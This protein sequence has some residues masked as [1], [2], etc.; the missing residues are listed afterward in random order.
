MFSDLLFRIARFF[1]SF[2]V[3]RPVIT[4]VMVHRMTIRVE[5]R[6]HRYSLWTPSDPKDPMT[7][8]FD[9]AG[10]RMPN[11]DLATWTNQKDETPTAYPSWTG[12][13]SR[14]HTGRH[15][16][17]L[18][19][20]AAPPRPKLEDV[21]AVQARQTFVPSQHT[22]VLLCFFAQWFTD[23]FLRTHPVKHS[24]TT[25]NH[26]ID[27]CQ[28]YGLD[29]TSTHALRLHRHGLLSYRGYPGAE[30]PL[31]LYKNGVLDKGF[32][33]PDSETGLT[34]LR[35]GQDKRWEAG[36]EKSLKVAMDSPRKGFLYA[37]GLDRGSSTIL[38]SAFNT[39]FLR[40]HNRIARVLR[41]ANRDWD[42]NRL[43]EIARL[44]NIR[45]LLE[46]VMG[47]YIGHLTGG[48]SVS[49]LKGLGQEGA[50]WYRTNRISI[51]FNLLYRWHALIPE[52]FGLGGQNLGEED[53]R[54]NNQ[55]LETHGVAAVIDAGSRQSAGALTLFNT[56]TFMKAAEG[57]GLAWAREFGV[58]GLNAYRRRFG[59]K[60]YATIAEM[61]GGGTA[62]A[63]L[64]RIYHGDVEAV[65]FSVGLFAEK[66]VAGGYLPETL[67]D[68]VAY[69][70]FTHIF[71]NP[72]LGREVDVPA[73]FSRAG[74]DLLAEPATLA[75][76]VR[77]NTAYDPLAQGMTPLV[78]LGLA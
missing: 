76:I 8:R 26:E 9:L 27:L 58:Q 25:S 11:G 2:S 10:A 47:D 52:T 50:N 14:R 6:P 15:L 3:L 75:D 53:F 1:S 56:P 63:A 46:I 16:P 31:L 64:D 36:I 78:R 17:P 61:T 73:S 18:E 59:L 40:E 69:D 60:P 68:I 38:Y 19:T 5:P 13:V 39:L 28:I 43:F 67:R 23:S 4:R 32:F 7:R 42:D 22:S 30:Y 72:V 37:S 54:F 65:E 41:V 49:L 62:G 51:E 12:L 33:D 24:F 34:Y 74:M 44:I 48:L 57:R 70:A 71:T 66:T 77:L 21:W 20:N 55:L 45:R 35:A 29:E